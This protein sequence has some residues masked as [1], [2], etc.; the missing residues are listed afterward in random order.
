DS[1]SDGGRSYKVEDAVRNGIQLVE[2]GADLLDVGGESTRPGSQSVSLEE[3]LARVIP[4]IRELSA[5]LN[6][7]LSVDTTKAEV[8]RQAEAAGAVIV[9][10]IS[11]LTFDPLMPKVCADLGVGVICMHMRGTPQTM[12]E[13][14]VY[15]DVIAEIRDFLGGRLH[16]LESAGIPRERVM[17]DPGIGFGKTAAQNVEILSQIAAFRAAGRPVLIGHSRKRFLKKVLG[18]PVD[19]RLHGTLG[20]SLALFCQSVDAIRLHEVAA[21]RDALLAFEAILGNRRFSTN[22]NG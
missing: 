13:N 18:R 15:D 9:N 21:T 6:V 2:D 12:Q 20:I 19:E 11:G 3:E 1:C 5:Q 8:A 7:P 16:N 17:L 22:G 4:V 14:P 10:D